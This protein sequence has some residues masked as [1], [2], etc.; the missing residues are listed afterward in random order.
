MLFYLASSIVVQ[1]F[2][3]LVRLDEDNELLDH[4]GEVSNS[5]RKQDL[6]YVLANIAAIPPPSPASPSCLPPP[7]PTRPQ[8]NNQPGL[9][10]AVLEKP[11][12]LVLMMLFGFEADTL[13]IALREQQ[14]LVDR[15]FI[16]ESTV[17]HK[18]LQKPLMWERLK[19]TH[20]FSFVNDSKI[21]HVVVDDRLRGGKR[22]GG[23]WFTE[24]RV[25]DLGVG[26]VREWAAG[27]E[28]GLAGEDVFI[29]AS[30]DEVLSRETLL[31]LRWCHLS[32]D[33]TTGALWMP[34]GNLERAFKSDFPVPGRPHTY[35]LPT[36]LKWHLVSSRPP[37]GRRVQQ[38][39]L[40]GSC[41]DEQTC[42]KSYL[43]GGIHLTNP[44]L[45]VQRILKEL[46]S[47]SD[48]L[49]GGFINT[50]RLVS[51]TR[52]E[53][54]LEQ[55]KLY[56]LE[57]QVCWVENSDPVSEAGDIE[58]RTPWW[59]GCHPHRYPYWFNRPESRNSDLVTALR[60]VN[61]YGD[62]TNPYSLHYGEQDSKHK[63]N[64]TL[65]KLFGFGLGIAQDK[66]GPVKRDGKYQCVILGE[67]E[68]GRRQEI[69][70]DDF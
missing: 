19:Y 57:A 25:T 10:G 22:T 11:R 18:G 21:W 38:Q 3:Q 53:A 56:R 49:Y 28:G 36:V 5:T 44:A 58:T 7:L 65:K 69:L 59:L 14:D 43:L 42:Y 6:L 37:M 26:A 20:R 47:T 61:L 41:Q 45:L 48:S 24:L 63:E 8:C 66:D 60:S 33:I 39:W 32:K 46:T 1:V 29:S 67:P 9:S 40:D 34:L 55:D 30:T 64:T 52:Q 23:E 62:Q 51:L 2:H 4:E 50:E 35:S 13:E 31:Q 27:R 54:D 17:T 70:V 15:I 12:K 68:T 16:V